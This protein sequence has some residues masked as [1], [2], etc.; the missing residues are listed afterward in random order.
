M[1]LKKMTWPQ[2]DPLVTIIMTPMK[3]KK[4]KNCK[5]IQRYLQF[6]FSKFRQ[7]STKYNETTTIFKEKLTNLS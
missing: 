2:K 6:C 5:P 3:K 1:F 4:K 7:P